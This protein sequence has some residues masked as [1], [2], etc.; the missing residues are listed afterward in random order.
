MV[1]SNSLPHVCSFLAPSSF[2]TLVCV[3]GG[4]PCLYVY[5]MEGVCGVGLRLSVFCGAGV[6][7][8]GF[9]FLCVFEHPARTG[10]PC[11]RLFRATLVSFEQQA[12]ILDQ[13]R[14][15]AVTALTYAVVIVQDAQ[16]FERLPSTSV[17]GSC[18]KMRVD[19]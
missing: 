12:I 19:L 16:L 8:C 13:P 2:R 5:L 15:R 4:G 3:C 17:F 11:A 9:V 6:F 7:V 10:R 14:R 18:A 1:N